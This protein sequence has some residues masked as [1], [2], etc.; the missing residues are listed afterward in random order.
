M[1][2][3][4]ADPDPN[5]PLEDVSIDTVAVTGAFDL[6]DAHVD[7]TVTGFNY[8]IGSD[9]A[10]TVYTSCVITPSDAGTAQLQ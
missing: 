4:T 1:D 6:G 9:K 3:R 7:K 8:A 10:T 2:S 5:S